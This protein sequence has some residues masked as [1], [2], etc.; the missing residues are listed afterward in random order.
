MTITQLINNRGNAVANQFII[1]DGGQV[2]FQSY[3]SKIA[4]YDK[5]TKQLTLYGQVWDYS[6]TTRKHFASFISDFTSFEY[7]TKKEFEKLIQND[8]N[9]KSL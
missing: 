6:N 5:D 7:G 4:T 3:R 9:I 1:T 2:T 8:I